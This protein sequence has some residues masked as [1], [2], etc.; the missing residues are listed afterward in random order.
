ML[1]GPVMAFW[2]MVALNRSGQDDVDNIPFCQL[3]QD[4]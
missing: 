1:G 2:G 3:C 4:F